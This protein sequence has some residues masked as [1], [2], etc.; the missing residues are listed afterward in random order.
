VNL[1][2]C[3]GLSFNGNCE[4]AFEFYARCLDGKL[5]YMLHW[6][7]SPMAADAPPEW[8]GKVFHARLTIGGI[9]LTGADAKPGTYEAPRGF[10][11][12]IG[13]E[14]PAEVERVFH[15]LAEGGTVGMPLQETFWAKRF[16]AVTDRFGLSWTLNCEQ[17]S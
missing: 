1:T 7:E 3:F 8:G 15:A 14:D 16:G 9:D 6:G 5:A 10:S 4:E 11:V 17:A 13:M 12:L 2:A